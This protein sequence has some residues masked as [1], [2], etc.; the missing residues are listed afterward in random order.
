MSSLKTRL[1]DDVKQ[2]LRAG[3]KPRLSTL[4]MLLA[5]IKQREVDERIELDDPAILSVLEKMVKQRKESIRQFEAGDRPD[6]AKI[7]AAEITVLQSY[8]PEPLDEAAL[9]QL[10][11]DVIAGTGA[12]GMQDMGRVMA[13]IKKRAAGRADMGDVSTLVKKA[14]GS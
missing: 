2:A 4:R 12:G 10:V 5:A 14:L 3:D 6:L 13:E 9:S 11:A 8:L 7:E 1:S